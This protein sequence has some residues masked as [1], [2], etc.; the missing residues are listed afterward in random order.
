MGSDNPLK[1]GLRQQPG[2]TEVRRW[3]VEACGG[4]VMLSFSRGKD[5]IGAWLALRDDG[6]EVVPMF[7]ETVPG[8]AFVE[9][10]LAYY[11]AFFGCRIWR[12]PH[13]GFYKAIDAALFQPPANAARLA[14]LHLHRR[15]EYRDC[16]DGLAEV[17]G[18][19]PW[20]ATGVR[21]SDSLTR[22]MA[23]ATHGPLVHSQKKAHVIWD[24]TPTI[25]M[26]RIKRSGV[27]LPVDYRMF[28][29]TFDGLGIEYLHA[30]KRFFPADYARILEFFPLAELEVFR[31]EQMRGA[32]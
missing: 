2:S 32:Q 26:E 25:L 30:V 8:L 27:M 3:V 4:R 20:Y 29:R 31:D 17:A 19:A 9:E 22:R 21:A 11:E 10:S 5:A 18:C 13:P 15:I 7:L 28:G 23:L 1:R 16:F 24:W 6:A 12:C 14:R